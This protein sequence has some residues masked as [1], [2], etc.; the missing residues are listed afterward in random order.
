[1]GNVIEDI[2]EE[3]L[4][5]LNTAFI[6][7][8]VSVQRP[9]LCTVQPIDKIKAYGKAAKAQSPITR[10]P[11]LNHVRHYEL[12]EQSLT[13]PNGSVTPNPHAGHLKVTPLKAGDLVL[14]VCA[15]RDITSSVNGVSTVPP[16]GHHQIGNA[17]VVGLLG[18]WEHEGG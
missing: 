16:A 7:R 1:M 15:Q 2:V 5:N 4:M 6:A 18:A 9:D 8:V 14:C 17:I 11:I 10:V 12:V 13:I 3:K